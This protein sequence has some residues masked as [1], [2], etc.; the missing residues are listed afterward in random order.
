MRSSEHRIQYKVKHEEPEKE[1]I[2]N[3]CEIVSIFHL[4][5]SYSYIAVVLSRLQSEAKY[6]DQEGEESG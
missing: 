6:S 3:D 4:I 1:I 5:Y 2:R